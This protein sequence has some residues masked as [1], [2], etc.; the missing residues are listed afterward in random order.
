MDF[1]IKPRSWWD[2]NRILSQLPLS[3]LAFVNNNNR[4]YFIHI[5]YVSFR[6]RRVISLSLST[7]ST[8]STPPLG[9]YFTFFQLLL[10]CDYS[11][12]VTDI[13]TTP[14]MWLCNV[15]YKQV[16]LNQTTRTKSSDT[17][18]NEFFITIRV[19]VLYIIIYIY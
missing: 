16:I 1:S 12:T 19:G 11:L 8:L 15:H 18:A 7:L 4:L 17:E 6:I 2:F 5:Y 3:R 13:R 10:L 14:I 9:S